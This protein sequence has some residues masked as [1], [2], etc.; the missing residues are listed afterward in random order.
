LSYNR[1]LLSLVVIFSFSVLASANS[2]PVNAASF[3]SNS[4][5]IESTQTS[6]S[7]FSIVRMPATVTLGSSA[8]GYTGTSNTF[9]RA[10]H[11]TISY[12]DGNW[13]VWHQKTPQPLSTPEPG[14]LLLVSTGLIGVAGTVRRKLQ[15]ARI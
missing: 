14:S 12:K 5:S 8:A 6:S 1:I 11:G 15:D 2:V 4:A 13:A 3:H 7:H 9:L 10:S